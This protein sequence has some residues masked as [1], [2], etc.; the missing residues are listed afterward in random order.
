MRFGPKT[1]AEDIFAF[2]KYILP[3]VLD[4]GIPEE[5]ID[6]PIYID[7]N[8]YEN[9]DPRLNQDRHHFS[10]SNYH[11][12]MRLL[13]EH[14]VKGINYKTYIEA[15]PL[16]L[17][18][19]EFG[20][21]LQFKFIGEAEPNNPK[22]LKAVALAGGK[23]TENYDMQDDGSYKW[24]G[25]EESFANYIRN[26]I[27]G[28]ETNEPFRRYI[29]ELMGVGGMPKEIIMFVGDKESYVDGKK[30]ILDVAPIIQNDR[31]LV[32]L[33]FIVENLGYEAIWNDGKITLRK[34]GNE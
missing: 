18:L 21:W 30:T 3:Y 34:W 24:V 9:P 25:A 20:H 22:W 11:I 10:P 32:P 6:V 5:I 7:H 14:E 16:R 27:V 28:T 2:R 12:F 31:T 26:L 13:N 19:H 1:S 33:R 23:I 4:F 15:V 8:Y 17:F 29:L